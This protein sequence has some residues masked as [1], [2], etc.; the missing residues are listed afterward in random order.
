MGAY[1]K[2]AIG[3]HGPDPR[4]S[5]VVATYA[6]QLE[7]VPDTTNLLP[8]LCHDIMSRKLGRPDL[9]SMQTEDE[10][11]TVSL[12]RMAVGVSCIGEDKQ[13]QPRYERLLLAGL[14]LMLHPHQSHVFDPDI[15]ERM[16]VLPPEERRYSRLGW[17]DI[18]PF[19]QAVRSKRAIDLAPYM[20]EGEAVMICAYGQ[21][22]AMT[23]ELIQ[24]PDLL[25][26]LGKM[27]VAEVD[28]DGQLIGDPYG[29]RAYWRDRDSW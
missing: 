10:L 3:A 14:A 26:H 12:A 29:F 19:P 9:I 15:H 17:T 1:P 20:P 21:C 13:N 2:V 8:F 25:A 23:S 7:G 28:Y 24:G 11:G 6:P 18:E 4:E 27:S 16:S 22:L 5:A